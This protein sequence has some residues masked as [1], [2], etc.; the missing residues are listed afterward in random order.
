[1]ELICPPLPEFEARLGR[2]WGLGTHPHYSLSPGC[3]R[4]GQALSPTAEDPPTRRSRSGE[5]DGPPPPDLL[6]IYPS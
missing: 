6:G 5:L 4:D 3:Q 2:H 1:M